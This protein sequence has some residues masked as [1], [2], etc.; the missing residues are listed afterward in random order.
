MHYPRHL[1]PSRVAILDDLAPD[2]V[3]RTI[4][5]LDACARQGVRMVPYM[6]TRSAEVQARFWRQSRTS[7][8]IGGR[9]SLLRKRQVGKLAD[10][11]EGV[12][13][14]SGRWATNAL[15]GQSAHQYG[16]AVDCFLLLENGVAEWD[17]NASG[18]EVYAR[19]AEGAGLVAG[20][21]F[22]DPVHIEARERPYDPKDWLSIQTALEAEGWL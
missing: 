19:A 10:L 18:Y 22:D 9:C 12:G 1:T 15:P 5:V 4:D 14:Q 13:P 8:V 17:G 21:T 11:I 7:E 6:G 2:M 16:L 3:A 20:L